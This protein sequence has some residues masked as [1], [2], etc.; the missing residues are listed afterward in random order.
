MHSEFK[1]IWCKKK[2][3]K[4]RELMMYFSH[5]LYSRN[6]T[7]QNIEKQ[8]SASRKD[9]PRTTMNILIIRLAYIV[10]KMNYYQL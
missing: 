5:F 6:F 7:N 2:K 4:K 8:N 3:K 1:V 10:I 9:L